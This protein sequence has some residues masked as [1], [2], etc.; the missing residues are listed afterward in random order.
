M[1]QLFILLTAG[2]LAVLLVFVVVQ[3]LIVW[4]NGRPVAA[5]TIPRDPQTFGVGSKL[6][7]VVMG[8][9]TTIAQGAAYEDG[10]ALASVQHLAQRH[11]VTFINVGVSGATAQ[12]VAEK[13]AQQAV[14]FKPDVVLIAVG[15]ND[16]THLTSVASVESSIKST[17]DQLRAAHPN[18]RIAVT[19]S[20]AMDTV[21]RFP[22]SVQQLALRRVKA[23]NRMFE[24]I[25]ASHDLT[26]VPIADQTREAFKRDPTLFAADKFHPNARGYALW[27]PIINRA[28]DE[29]LCQ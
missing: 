25:A 18:V 14:G 26:F 21:D 29:A 15:A 7:Y 8:D 23:L 1:R 3:V 5:P 27:T 24:R 17:L 22:W 28:L 11:K 2:V 6:T 12:D 16:V 20:P 9:S 19:G 13:Q 4:L 10:Y